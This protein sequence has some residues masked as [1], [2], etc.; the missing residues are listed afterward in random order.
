MLQVLTD[1]R[2]ANLGARAIYDAFE[3][4][5][6][7]FKTI[8]R[9]A[10]THFERRDWRTMQADAAARLDLYADVIGGIVAEVREL[11]GTRVD[12]KLVWASIKAVYS[13][14]I[15]PRDDWELAET[16][17]N[18]I[19]RRIFTTEGVDQQIEF[20]DTDFDAPP[21]VSTQPMFRTCVAPPSLAALISRILADYAFTVAYE[22]A[23][24]DARLAAEHIGEYLHALGIPMTVDRAEVLQPVF[25][26]GKGAYIIGRMWCSGTP[27]PLVLALRNHE[28]GIALDAVLFTEDEVSILFSFTRSYFHVDVARPYDCVR[29]LL[30]IMPRKP[31]AELYT[32]I[33]YNKHGKTELY[34]HF[35]RHLK[36]GNDQFIIAPGARG[37]VMLVLT[38]PSYDAVFKIIKDSF[39]EPKTV[40]RADV[41]AKY[42]LVFKHDRAGRLIDAQEF[43][44]LEFDR[45]NF[46]EPVIEEMQR[47]AANTVRVDDHRVVIKHLYVERRVRPLNIYVREAS[48]EAVHAAVIDYGHSIKNL[49]AANI[50]PGDVL[51]K[52]FG[53]TRHGRIVSYD[54]D[55]L[56]LLTDCHFVEAP[57]PH[58][59]I[60]ELS[61]DPWYYVRESDVFPVELK[62]WLGLEEP[63]RSVF[64]EHHGDLY[65]VGFWRDLQ[66]RILAGEVI[67]ILPYPHSKRLAI[68]RRN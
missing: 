7:Q 12:D 35:L 21:T 56:C 16:F 3:A 5:H 40:T 62:A 34:R 18:S 28:R 60:E 42:R 37:T 39:D 23:G 27:L 8:T 50:F 33:G 63:W 26:R 57:P 41:M 19:T 51:L 45:A 48:D 44:H 25:Y 9:R 29:F 59:D 38:L 20:V 10:R 47:V 11:L 46:S 14:M 13:G 61:A 58:D 17:F 66:S 65:E 67:D 1:S 52:N 6:A 15:A 68:K 30:K 24:R 2:L 32:A 22:D 36:A 31:Q 4:Y 43:E 49:A 55:E 64:M 53:V 54:Y